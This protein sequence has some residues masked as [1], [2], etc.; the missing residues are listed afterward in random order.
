VDGGAGGGVARTNVAG[1][2]AVV[3]P[4]LHGGAVVAAER[5]LV[6][7]DANGAVTKLP[8]VWTDSGVRMN[9][10]GCDPQGRF[11]CGS[12]AYDKA[13]GVG[14]L[15]RLDPDLSVHAVLGGVTISNGLEWSPDASVAYYNDTPTHRISVF[16][17][18][19]DEGL[20]RRRT[21]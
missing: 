4:R 12:M 9:D 8:D 21:F 17:Q 1:V 3:R 19:P 11:Y 2:A 14:T 15:Y 7:V 5:G 6:L 16:D 20:V 13:E 10:G 18:D